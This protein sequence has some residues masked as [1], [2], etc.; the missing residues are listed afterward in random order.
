[1]G[2]IQVSDTGIGIKKENQKIIFDEFRQ[3]SEGQTRNYDGSGLGLHISKRFAEMM[4]GS[5][6]VKS[7]HE[8]GSTFT[9]CLPLK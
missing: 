7:K 6:I 3:V 5:I 4:G 9:L 1:F 2:C 8:A